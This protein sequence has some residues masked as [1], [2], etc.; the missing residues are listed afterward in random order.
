MDTRFWGPS[1]WQL[2]HAIAYAYPD[3]PDPKTKERYEL[4]FGAIKDV[5]PCKFC[6]ESTTRFISEEPPKFDNRRALT[7]WIYDLHNKVNAKLRGQCKEDPKVICPPPDPSLEKVDEIYQE[8]LKWDPNTPLGLDFL[9][10]L[11]YN[12]K[13]NPA[14]QSYMNTFGILHYIYPFKQLRKHIPLVKSEDLR[15]PSIFFKWW[16][17]VA[18]KMCRETGT[19]IGTLRGTLQK[20]GRYKSGCNRGKTCRN[21]QKVRDHRKTFKITHDRLVRI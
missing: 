9:F 2:F 14:R 20:Y 11:A 17:S 7:K 6:R 21:G 10:C 4:F 3:T 1:G 5:L 8:L 12:Y 18:K 16:Y 13:S 15:D 19:E